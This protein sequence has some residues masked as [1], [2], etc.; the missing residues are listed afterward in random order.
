MSCKSEQ[1]L[2]HAVAGPLVI[3]FLILLRS[4]YVAKCPE[5]GIFW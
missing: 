5:S 4:L 2:L 1:S 3:G